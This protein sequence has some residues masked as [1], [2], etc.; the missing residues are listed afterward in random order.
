M[1]RCIYRLVLIIGLSVL[2]GGC[3]RSEDEVEVTEMDVT[4]ETSKDEISYN[5]NPKVLELYVDYRNEYPDRNYYM[6][7]TKNVDGKEYT[8]YTSGELVVRNSTEKAISFSN[9]NVENTIKIDY[10]DKEMPYLQVYGFDFTGDG[11]DELV[12]WWD[13][14]ESNASGERMIILDT[15]SL[16]EITYTDYS[17]SRV[18][19]LSEEIHNW[20]NAALVYIGT[21]HWMARSFC[22]DVVDGRLAIYRTSEDKEYVAGFFMEYEGNSF[23]QTEK[24]AGRLIDGKYVLENVPENISWQS[25]YCESYWWWNKI[26]SFNGF[27]ISERIIDGNMMYYYV[28]READITFIVDEKQENAALIHN[29]KKVEFTIENMLSA[30]SDRG[31]IYYMDV[32]GDGKEDF[33]YYYYYYENSQ[34]TVVDMETMEICSF[35]IDLSEIKV[36]V[37]A[38]FKDI[39]GN[40]MEGYYVIYDVSL[41]GKSEEYSMYYGMTLDGSKEDIL[42][43]AQDTLKIKEYRLAFD[44]WEQKLYVLVNVYCDLTYRSLWGI[45]VDLSFD[46]DRA[47]FIVD[48]ESFWGRLQEMYDMCEPAYERN[49]YSVSTE[50]FDGV[51]YNVYSNGNITIRNSK[52]KLISFSNG[53]TEKCFE[54][55]YINEEDTVLAVYGYDFTG[56]GI[57]ELVCWWDAKESEY[58]G[59]RLLIVDADTLEEIR[60]IGYSDESFSYNSAYDK[61]VPELLA[62]EHEWMNAALLYLGAPTADTR[63]FNCEVVDGRLVIYR[64]SANN[65]CVAGYYMEYMGSRFSMTE[66][67]A[68]RLEN[69]EYVDVTIPDNLRWNL[70][71]K[72]NYY[73]Y[74]LDDVF[75]GFSISERYIAGKDTMYCYEYKDKSEDIVFLVNKNQNEGML[76]HGDDQITFSIEGMLSNTEA[77][78]TIVYED[79]TGDGKREFIY[80]FRYEAGAGEELIY[81]VYDVEGMEEMELNA[82]SIEFLVE[83]SGELF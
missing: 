1:F 83:L 9:G 74:N 54:I 63:C 77:K 71:F 12:C 51:T 67:F 27:D 80:L 42:K 72:E 46:A 37:E 5:V 69:G 17:Q 8:V 38:D 61:H 16:Q 14:G 26:D 39:T 70:G 3:T 65:E 40:D 45:S 43:Q 68:K 78:G 25:E 21:E 13:A 66:H 32:T 2:L 7:S 35:D 20:L 55:D 41:Y 82:D 48:E 23:V 19:A 75:N 34:I 53:V 79:I 15:K 11:I 59:E 64:A 57:D 56:D 36:A 50:V 29:G 22:C 60:Y 24:F 44:R 76:I 62:E 81:K 31:S 58:G 52:D 33:V 30:T 47:A 28:H 6:P 49:Y 10:I 18:P 4:E 73:K